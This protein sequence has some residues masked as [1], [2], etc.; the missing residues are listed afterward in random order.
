MKY[1]LI[2]GDGMAD[3]PVPE[4][5]GLTPLQKANIPGIDALARAG[6]LGSVKNIPK[7]LPPGSDTAM[8]SI[9]GCPTEKCYSGRAP[10]EAAAQG[11]VL[12][13]GS[14]AFR[15]N[16]IAISEG[17]RFEDRRILSHSGGTIPGKESHELIE[18]LF[19]HPDFAPLAKQARMS[20]APA[21][22]YRH[23][24]FRKNADIKGIS[25]KPPHDHLGEKVGDNLPSGC[26]DAEVLTTLMRAAVPIL[27]AH[28][29]NK[30][31]R[32]AGKLPA[33]AIWFWAEGTAAALPDFYG[34][35]GKTGAVISA[36]PLCHGI[37]RL[38]GLDIIEVEGATGELDTN[39]EGKVDAAIEALKTHDF[40]TV[41]VEAPDEC[42]HNGDLAGKVQAIEWL[43]SRVV[44]PLIRK[45]YDGGEDF[46]MLIL[47]D[48]KTL[49]RDGAHDGDPV[50]FIIYDSREDRHTG[51]SYTE[52]D[53]LRG[54]MIEKGSMLMRELFEL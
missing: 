9:M 40:V 25:L 53:G 1:I 5:G 51:L 16:N 47:S 7:G 22:S 45:L 31:R 42:T 43:D 28:P 44:T 32:A 21:D 49:M 52:A 36:V 8:L 13:P 19:S 3:N 6:R 30:R 39:L 34:Q 35:F 29:I 46:R 11:I 24:A 17:E 33:N 23:L 48:H 2:I 37:G 41:H 18:A 4:L 10:L 50:P 20:V 38:V 12:E 26:A 54:E 27:E 15:C 14:A